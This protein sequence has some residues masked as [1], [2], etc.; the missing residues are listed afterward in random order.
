MQSRLLPA[1]S[2]SRLEMTSPFVIVGVDS[3]T[4]KGVKQRDAQR[5]LSDV[6]EFLLT[7]GNVNAT[8]DRNT[9]LVG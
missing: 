7:G 6:K 9:S 1:A 5:M 8:N 4:L 3:T 2:D